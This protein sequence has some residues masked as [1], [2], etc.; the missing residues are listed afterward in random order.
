MNSGEKYFIR[1]QEAIPYTWLL[2]PTPLPQH[3]VI[4][5]LEIQDWREAGSLSQKER[6]LLLKV[7]GFSPLGWGS[8]G[9]SL[10][11]DLPHAEWQQ[12]IE[13]AL[14]NFQTSPTILQRFHKGHLFDHRYWNSEGAELLTMKGRVRLC[15]YYFVEKRQREIARRPG[16]DRAGRQ[17]IVARHEGRHPRSL[18][19]R[20]LIR[21]CRADDFARSARS[22]YSDPADESRLEYRVK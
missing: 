7:S 17:E 5:R 4:P 14:Q 10:G 16:D 19:A 21:H 15:P 9:V 1:L 12:R 13:S 6:D 20:G 3:A 11:R 2:D 8:R 18:G 22:V